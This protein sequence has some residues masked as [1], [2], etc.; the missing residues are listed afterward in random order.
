MVTTTCFVNYSNVAFPLV[1]RD[2][3][4]AL[5]PKHSP[6]HS[7]LC[8]HVSKLA[9]DVCM[10][11]RVLGDTQTKLAYGNLGVSRSGALRT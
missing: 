1:S 3:Y 2:G 10:F 8:Q 11:N 6:A 9:T 4:V 7:E 5:L